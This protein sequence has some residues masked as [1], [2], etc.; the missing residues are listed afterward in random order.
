M[1]LMLKNKL[2]YLP[3]VFLFS[4][5]LINGQTVS[6]SVSVELEKLF[7]R[8]AKSLNDSVKI[9]VNDSIRC[10]VESYVESDT[11]FNHKFN[12]LRYLGQVTSPDSVLKIVTW[13]LVLINKPGRYY[14]YIIK[15]Q[16][17]GN[18]N[19]IYRLTADYNSGHIRTD[20]T[21]SADNWYGALY[22][23]IRTNTLND[24]IYWVL[25]GIDY[26][27]PMI[28]RKIIEILNFTPYD[29]IQFG[30]KLF[31]TPDTIKYREVF[32]YSSS[33]TIS[34]RFANDGSIVFDHLIPFSPEQ[35][36]DRQFYGPQYSNDAYIR[37]DGLWRLN[38]NVDA[39]NIE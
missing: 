6:N 21:Y 33:A 38:I 39:R 9:Q 15:K 22:Y 12:N 35:T 18:R 19:L 13:N 30:M 10:I 20:T 3:I 8:L 14:S 26:G 32:E 16:T 1:I 17:N 2:A 23:D 27:N 4:V 25:L 37:E 11:V 5:N 28:T 36:N 7:G 24:P 29:K 31:S 34:L